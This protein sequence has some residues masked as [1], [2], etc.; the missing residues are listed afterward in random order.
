[1]GC[2]RLNYKPYY[3]MV[4]EGR[5]KAPLINL[6]PSFMYTPYISFTSD[7]FCQLKASLYHRFCSAFQNAPSN[8]HTHFKVWQ[9]LQIH[10]HFLHKT[11][12]IIFHHAVEI[13][14]K[15][16]PVSL[17][18]SFNMTYFNSYSLLKT[19]TQNIAVSSFHKHFQPASLTSADY[20][21]EL[22]YKF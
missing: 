15:C 10:L 6:S 14:L 16:A 20:P 2:L 9:H 11:A 12:F 13:F 19:K 8:Y 3:N 22:R 7:T 4:E 18:E 17:F 5:R 21:E 1:M